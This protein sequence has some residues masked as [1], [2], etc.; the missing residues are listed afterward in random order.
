MSDAVI[1]ITELAER[2]GVK[3][4]Y[5]HELVQKGAEGPFP[6]AKSSTPA[7]NAPILI[8]LNEAEAWL[9]SRKERSISDGET[10]RKIP[11]KL[12]TQAKVR[13]R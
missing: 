3:R 5:V 8:P 9:K 4:Q 2:A 12:A 10:L 6:G 11:Q 13:G 1:S 7:A